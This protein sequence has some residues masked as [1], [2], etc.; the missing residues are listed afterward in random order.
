MS[1]AT[2]I[3]RTTTWKSNPICSLSRSTT[4]R[5]ENS[6][7][8]PVT[9]TIC[10]RD[11]ACRRMLEPPEPDALNS[12]HPVFGE[13]PERR[14]FARFPRNHFLDLTRQGH[15]VPSQGVHLVRPQFDDDLRVADRQVGVVPGRL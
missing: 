15:V 4:R 11:A 1:A 7:S 5:N 8:L 6:A 2:L 13:A 10:S 9:K 12:V 14:S 3:G